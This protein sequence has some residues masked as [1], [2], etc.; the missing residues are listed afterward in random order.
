MSVSV[1]V[2]P[3]SASAE[4]TASNS[5]FFGHIF[6][7]AITKIVIERVPSIACDVDVRQTI[8]VVIADSH[9][10]SPPLMRKSCGRCDIRKMKVSVLMI[11]GYHRVAAPLV[12][13]DCRTIHRDD[14]ELSVVVAI[15]QPSASAHGFNDIA[16]IHRRNMRNGKTYL[17]GHIFEVRLHKVWSSALAALSERLETQQQNQNVSRAHLTQYRACS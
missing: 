1:I 11:E 12:A 8:V 14:V 4:P 9:A 2:G 16:L 17:L 6:K 7:L 15:N 5:G 13:I 10:H 3:R